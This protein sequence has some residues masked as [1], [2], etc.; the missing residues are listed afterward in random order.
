MDSNFRSRTSWRAKLEKD[1]DH[2]G[3]LPK[4][5]PMPASMAKRLG[6]GT[7]L[8]P[9]PLDVDAAIRK[10]RRGQLITPRQIRETL[11]KRFKADTTCPLCTGIFVRIAAEAAEEDSR[12]GLKTI[13][14]YWRVVRDDGSLNEKFPGG[15]AAQ[16]RRLREEGHS[17]ESG[18]GKKPPKVRNFQKGLPQR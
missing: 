18:T 10:V 13:T 2:A 4:V 16:A 14:P 9:R 1:S 8:I 17:I 15:V 3:P 6:T 7:L 5:V 11:A 12:A